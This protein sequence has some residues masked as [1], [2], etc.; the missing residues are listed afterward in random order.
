MK[1]KNGFEE[2]NCEFSKKYFIE[3]NSFLKS[4]ESTIYPRENDIFRVFNLCHMDDVKVI[5][6]GQDP[7]HQ[8]NQANGLAFSVNKDTSHPRSLRNIFKEVSRDCNCPYPQIGDL[9]SWAKQGVFLLNT[10]LTVSEGSPSSHKNKGWEKFTDRVIQLLDNKKTNLVFMLWGKY[11]QTKTHLVTKDK[12]LI[13][14]ASHPSPFS[15][16]ISFNGCSHFSK[17]NYYLKKNNITPINW[18]IE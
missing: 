3:L 5:I 8:P 1:L 10:I 14:T 4:V 9:T 17:A 6:L 15:A 18:C 13:L 12:H 2:L 7:Y 16:R 11:A